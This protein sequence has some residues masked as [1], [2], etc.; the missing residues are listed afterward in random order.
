[1]K[2]SNDVLSKILSFIPLKTNNPIAFITSAFTLFILNLSA[3]TVLLLFYLVGFG[4]CNLGIGYYLIAFT[5]TTALS[6]PFIKK[7]S[8]IVFQILIWIFLYIVWD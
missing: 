2:E 5:V 3:F 8:L 6:Y 4:C 7:K 1:M